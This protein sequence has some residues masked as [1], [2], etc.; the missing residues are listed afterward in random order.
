MTTDI[1]PNLYQDTLIK[2]KNGQRP[3]IKLSVLL[4][5]ELK[6]NWQKSLLEV[7]CV[8]NHT[9][10]S[11][12]EFNE[13]IIATF[14]KELDQEILIFLLGASQKHIIS[15]SLTTGMMVP[16][17]FF[18]ILKN[19]LQTKKPEVLEW[20][21]RTIES[22]GPLNRRL[23]N[24]IRKSKPGLNKLFNSHLRASDEIINLLEEQ[25]KK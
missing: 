19:L 6:A 16:A 12:V 5:S 11:T 13:L 7:L 21:L 2:L 4:V 14:H 25:W 20:T 24:E 15:H 10:N 23:Q 3:Q 8:L 9:Q 22:M 17:E 1:L 18:E